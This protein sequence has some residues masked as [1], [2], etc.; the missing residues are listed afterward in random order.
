MEFTKNGTIINEILNIYNY[1]LVF[2]V[3][4]IN[5]ITLVPIFDLIAFIR[6]NS[7][8]NRSCYANGVV[9][10]GYISPI[11]NQWQT[12]CVNCYLMVFILIT[13]H[14][15]ITYYKLHSCFFIPL[16]GAIHVAFHHDI[17][18]LLL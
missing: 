1:V 13:K 3:K 17:N 5:K 10:T 7:N 12:G 6:T 18:K 2:F 8:M 14:N 9:A 11:V 15:T 4:G 16:D